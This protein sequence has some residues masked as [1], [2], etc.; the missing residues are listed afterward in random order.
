MELHELG[1]FKNDCTRCG[2]SLG[3]NDRVGNPLFVDLGNRDYRLRA[4]SLAVD[5][6]AD[7]GYKLD[8]DSNCIP[9]GAAPDMGTYG[10][11][12]EWISGFHEH[13][14]KEL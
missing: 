6:G 8:I 14:R 4:E 13:R 12:G 9:V 7:L 11:A 10:R 3:K 5:T 2:A 1:M